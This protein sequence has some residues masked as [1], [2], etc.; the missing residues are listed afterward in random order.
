MGRFVE[1]VGALEVRRFGAA[2]NFE[3]TSFGASLLG[4]SLALTSVS[5]RRTL[6]FSVTHGVRDLQLV[7]ARIYA[8]AE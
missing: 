7:A 5:L 4:G 3:A 2:A 1:I 6:H 8:G